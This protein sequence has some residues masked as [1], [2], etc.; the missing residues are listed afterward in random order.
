MFKK[1]T[2]NLPFSP[3]IFSFYQGFIGSAKISTHPVIN[4]LSKKDSNS[5]V[6]KLKEVHIQFEMTGK[7]S[8][9]GAH[10]KNIS[11]HNA[12]SLPEKRSSLAN[13]KKS[14]E[15]NINNCS[16]WPPER[17]RLVKDLSEKYLSSATNDPNSSSQDKPLVGM[18]SVVKCSPCAY[19]AEIFKTKVPESLTHY[20]FDQTNANRTEIKRDVLSR[21]PPPAD[22]KQTARE[23]ISSAIAQKLNSKD[24]TGISTTNPRANHITAAPISGRWP[25]VSSTDKEPKHS[26]VSAE[27][28]KLRE[29][30]SKQ[31]TPL[32]NTSLWSQPEPISPTQ[33][34]ALKNPTFHNSCDSINHLTKDAAITGHHSLASTYSL[35]ESQFKLNDFHVSAFCLFSFILTGI[36]FYK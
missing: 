34:H 27:N 6:E 32:K 8:T 4:G 9:T 29:K 26:T 21:W 14:S 36:K 25:P 22:P 23:S 35:N 1:K 13:E 12:V 5:K 20:S 24:L 17:G 28:R 33:M 2:D 18:K 31:I 30:T 16:K 15:E 10:I 3:F 19:K 7:T 11:V